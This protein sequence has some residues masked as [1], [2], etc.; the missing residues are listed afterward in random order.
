MTAIPLNAA[1]AAAAARKRREQEE[2]EM[3][4]YKEQELSGDWE[5]K[6]LRSMTGAFGKPDKLREILAE[7]SRAGWI[8]VEKFDNSRI[9]LKR[10]AS[11]RSAD[12]SLGFDA[13]RTYV[14]M[15]EGRFTLTL[16][17][18]ILGGMLFAMLAIAGLVAVL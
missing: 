5:F 9:R 18:L 1:A 12:D 10:R 13:Y 7:E 16:V 2:E 15:S 11:D 4:P 14:G 8:L 17:A 3:T 6:I